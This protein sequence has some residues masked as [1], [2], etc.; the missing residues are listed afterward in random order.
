MNDLQLLGTVAGLIYSSIEFVC[1][2]VFVIVSVIIDFP[3]LRWMIGNFLNKSSSW[4]L[5]MRKKNKLVEA[6]WSQVTKIKT[7]NVPY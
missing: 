7:F 2:F 1:L 3:S 4:K 5:M 6:V